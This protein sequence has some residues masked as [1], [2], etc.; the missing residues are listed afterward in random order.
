MTHRSSRCR[1]PSARAALMSFLMFF[2]GAEL[3]LTLVSERW[4]AELRDPEYSSKR[5]GLRALM[6]ANPGRPLVLVLGSS[7]AG[8][9][10]RPGVLGLRGH[11]E[12]PPPL[13]YNFALTG[14]GAG[15][16]LLCLHRLLEEGIR[17]KLCLIEVCLALL[18]R[19]ELSEEVCPT[20]A[21]L[22]WADLPIIRR[23]ASHPWRPY[24]RWL[25]ARL[26]PWYTNRF[27]LLSRFMPSWVN[28]DDGPD[29]HWRKLDPEGWLA[30]YQTA[31]S[32]SRR[33]GAERES[34]AYEA[35][36]EHF[37]ITDRANRALRDALALCQSQGTEVILILMPEGGEFRSWYTPEARQ[38]G[39]SYL[40]QLAEEFAV[41]V[42]DARAWM[43]DADFCDSHHLLAGAA[44][45]F[46]KRFGREVLRPY[47]ESG[48]G[49][50]LLAHREGMRK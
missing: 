20:G 10:F 30:L 7:H 26:V 23:F 21:V 19:E 43:A 45:A 18:N 5:A 29:R 46:S 11:G 28:Q 16:E 39:R 9:G 40:A 4:H 34:A 50:G 33:L 44:T 14:S 41:P 35:Q 42:I 6:A 24:S 17:P 36:F 49:I 2:A 3:A 27:H 22:D 12:D 32:E 48:R 31:T 38:L 8:L 1:R 13:V 37:R 47:L 25:E 15:T